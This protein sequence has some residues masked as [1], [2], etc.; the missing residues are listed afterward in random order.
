MIGLLSILGL[1][2]ALGMRHATDADHVVAVA[3]IVSQQRDF[4][5][6][7]ATGLAW[8]IGHTFTIVLVGSAVILLNLVIPPRVGLAME[9]SVGLTLIVLGLWTQGG[10]LRRAGV[11]VP[12][13]HAGLEGWHFHGPSMSGDGDDAAPLNRLDRVFGR[14][15]AYRLVRPLVVGVV[16]GLAGSAAVAL[17]V[18]T[19]ISDSRWAVAYLLVFGLGTIAGMMVITLSLVST[20]RYT[21]DRYEWLSRRLALASGAVC[22]V[23]GLIITYQICM[24]DGLFSAN[25]QW[26]PR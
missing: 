11:R 15:A 12:H 17:L 3:S 6:A 9:L 2:F 7:A 23:F 24:V 4:S 20:F 19:T 26:T 10:A 1:G 13:S 21:D 22:L 14:L 25:P 5:R 8:G 18:L 16:H